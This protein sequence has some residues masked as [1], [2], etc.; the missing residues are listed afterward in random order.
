MG[1]R[2][3]RTQAG[4]IADCLIARELNRKLLIIK[5]TYNP[6]M[7]KTKRESTIA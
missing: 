3:K 1:K 4:L 6:E 5:G 7:D 2:T